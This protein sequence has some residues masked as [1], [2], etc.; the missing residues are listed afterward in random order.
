MTEFRKDL[1]TNTWIIM[2]PER[3]QRPMDVGQVPALVEELTQWDQYCPFCPGNELMTPPEV[4]AYRKPGTGSNQEGWTL[5][6][7]RNKYPALSPNAEPEPVKK[8]DLQ[9]S[10][11][12][13][14]YHEVVIE[15]T[16]HSRDFAQMD[17]GEIEDVIWVWRDR[18]LSLRADKRVRYALVFKNY[19]HS[20]GASL[21]H[22]HSQ[23]IATPMIPKK[24]K[25]EVDSMR[26]YY[27]KTGECLLC[28]MLH[29]EK[30]DG[31]RI[32]EENESF[33][34]YC[35]Y[36]SASAYEIMI[37]PNQHTPEFIETNGIG[38]KDLSQ[39]FWSVFRRLN[40]AVGGL[41][42]Y[43]LWIHNNPWWQD[44]DTSFFH[45]HIELVP[46]LTQLAGFEVGSGFF[47]NHTLP[48][49]AAQ[50]LVSIEIA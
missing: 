10:I 24:I 39:I 44:C 15:T 21:R 36:A 46:R 50:K 48:E 7:V 1:L 49:E 29:D 17:I 38:V 4:L 22:P 33:T 27:D 43:N 37:V 13:F 3:A 9:E 2:A 26:T 6:V 11:E 18:L 20:A 14:G 30:N 5:R 16:S 8:E 40:A 32:V 12:G 31:K 25:E 34:A 19:G 23:I 42:P 47:I 41:V 45:W 28:A 35:P